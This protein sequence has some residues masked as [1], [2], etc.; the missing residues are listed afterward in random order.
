MTAR[1]VADA[2]LILH[3]AFILWAIFGGLAVLWRRWALWAHLPALVW[4]IWI[5][6]SHG[7]C[8]LTPLENY[9]R[10]RAGQAGY[11]GGFIEHYLVSLIYPA[12]LTP[13]HQFWMAFGLVLINVG[14]YIF[15]WRRWRE[16]YA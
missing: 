10:D 15:V 16:R 7:I 8:P 5:E 11:E 4:G 12:G 13:T 3:L 2:V 9:F 6:L 1:L 14:I